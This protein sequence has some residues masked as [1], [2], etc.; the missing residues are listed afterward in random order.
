MRAILTDGAF[1]D[2][3]PQG[4]KKFVRV[5]LVTSLD[6]PMYGGRA[7][8]DAFYQVTAEM[9]NPPAADIIAAE[10]RIDALLEDNQT[11]EPVGYTRMASIRTSRIRTVVPDQVDPSLFWHQRGGIYEITMSVGT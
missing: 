10:N 11:L 9:V 4:A 6:E 2:A 7:Y 8:E 1:F 5:S 3:A